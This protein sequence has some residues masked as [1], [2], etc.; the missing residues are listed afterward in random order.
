MK[1]HIVLDTSLFVNPDSGRYFGSDPTSAFTGFLELA[2]A[3]PGLEFLMPPS[4]YAELMHFAEENKIPKKL[5]LLI[6]KKPPKKHEVKIPGVFIYT[7]VED[8][9]DRVDRGLRLS[10]RVVRESIQMEPPPPPAPGQKGPR[11]DADVIARLRESYRRIMRE[12]MLD[13]R[14]DVDLL[15]LAYETEPL[16][17]SADMGVLTWAENLGIS[18]LA[19]DHL[20]EFLIEQASKAVS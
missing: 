3:A 9:R 16:L 20:R 10:E 17:V 4:I 14:A 6:H 8:M 18:T 15:L 7:L 5:L 13:S 1:K 12:G 11:P 2:Q 19:H